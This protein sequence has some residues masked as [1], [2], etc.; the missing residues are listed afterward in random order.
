MESFVMWWSSH[1]GHIVS[2]LFST[3]LVS[4]LPIV[5]L[6]GAL[7]LSSLLKIPLKQAVLL[8]IIG[9]MLPIPF[10]IIGI[11]NLINWLSEHNLNKVVTIIH[12]K[13]EK[14]R[15]E[16][17]T[18]GFWGLVIFV[19][20]PLPG[21]GAWT[22]SIIAGLLGMNRWRATLAIFLGVCLA[23]LIMTTI[24]YGIIGHIVK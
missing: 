5:E 22:G 11:E 1:L 8:A 23:A 17:E 2:P 16:I 24:S 9:N 12:H 4:M 15:H 21:T 3:F 18:V 10:L 19:G 20:I 7:I 13:V 6:R 14:H